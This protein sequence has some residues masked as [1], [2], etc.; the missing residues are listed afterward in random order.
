MGFKDYFYNDFETSDNTSNKELLTHYY[1]DT[2][3]RVKAEIV[4]YAKHHDYQVTSINDDFGEIYLNH[5]RHDLI[6]TLV[7]LSMMEISV[8]IKAT[9]Y[10][11]IGLKRGIKV[12]KE[13]YQHLD[14][15]LSFKGVALYK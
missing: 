12:I 14:R 3:D 7:K 15:N 2:Y 1:R 9:T 11:L 10:Y 13:L 6:I 4:N 5:K 8:D